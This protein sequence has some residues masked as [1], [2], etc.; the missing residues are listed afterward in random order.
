MKRWLPLAMLVLALPMAGQPSRQ[1]PPAPPPTAE[2]QDLERALAAAGASP[3]EY[4]R[5][6][7]SHLAR[8][9]NTTRRAE[10][11]AAAARAA[12]EAGDTPDIIEWGERVLARRPDDLALIEAVARAL[13][14]GDSRDGWER[15]LR[16][17][18]HGEDLLREQLN[19]ALARGHGAPAD[20]RDQVDRELSGVLLIEARATG[21]LGRPADAL[22]LA[23]RAFEMYPSAEAARETAHW[24]ER[25]G[26]PLDAARSLADAITVP[27]PRTTLDDRARDRAL[28]DELYRRAKGGNAGEGDLLLEAFDRNVALVHA[29]Q[30]RTRAG[31]PNALIADPMEFTIAGL[32]GDKLHMASLKG[33]VVVLDFWATWCVPCREQHPL[34]DEVRRGFAANPDVVFLAIDTDDNREPVKAFLQQVRWDDRVYFDDGLARKLSVMSLPV[35]IVFDRSGK[36]FSRLTGFAGTEFVNTLT[37]RITAALK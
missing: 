34:L 26:Q 12:I 2:Q 15:G 23:R 32:D 21:K 31:D 13:G 20:L 7:E 27:D 25:L 6:I 14:A 5:A 37:E 29:L 22:G 1:K 35:T 18:H 4:L 24:Q 10:L 19:Q 11:E 9:P 28:M 33:K 30:L 8:Y 36:V 3:V 16:Y 17:A